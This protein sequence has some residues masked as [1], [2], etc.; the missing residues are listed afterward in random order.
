MLPSTWFHDAYSRKGAVHI[1]ALNKMR[2]DLL[3]HVPSGNIMICNKQ[4]LIK[5]HIQTQMHLT[6]PHCFKLALLC[7][8]VR[9]SL[10]FCYH[11]SIPL[12]CEHSLNPCFS[13]CRYNMASCAFSCMLPEA[14]PLQIG[15][16]AW[17]PRLFFFWSADP[18]ETQTPAWCSWSE[19]G[20]RWW[21]DKCWM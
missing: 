15:L 11:L 12:Q 2:P 18:T 14:T 4:T 5:L 16:S 3:V 19:L 20:G 17:S 1:P 8:T 7:V 10:F 13:V 9:D 21:R 6:V